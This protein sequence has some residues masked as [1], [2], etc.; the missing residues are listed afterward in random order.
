M[1]E[2][3]ASVKSRT[4]A[5]SFAES[6][7][8][9]LFNPPEPFT[10]I[11]EINKIVDW[12]NVLKTNF[13]NK[14]LFTFD[15]DLIIDGEKFLTSARFQKEFVLLDIETPIAEKVLI[16]LDQVIYNSY[17][18]ISLKIYD[19]LEEEVYIG[20][21][22]FKLYRE[23]LHLKTGSFLVLFW[24]FTKPLTNCYKIASAEIDDPFLD[25]IK[26]AHFSKQ[27]VTEIGNSF[28]LQKSRESADNY[29]FLLNQTLPLS[30]LEIH[31]SMKNSGEA[32][33]VYLDMPTPIRECKHTPLAF[34]KSQQTK[35]LNFLVANNPYHHMFFS[36]SVY[37]D[38]FRV[39]DFPY[40]F[41]RRENPVITMYKDNFKEGTNQDEQVNEDRH[42]LDQI[43][44]LPNFF[45]IELEDKILINKSHGYLRDIP[46]ALPKV[47]LSLEWSRITNTG[48]LR[49]LLARWKSI[50]YDDALFLLSHF[51][52]ANDIY[53]AKICDGHP[54]KEEIIRVIRDYAVDSL[55]E[56]IK[57]LEFLL[58]QLTASLKY[59]NYLHVKKSPLVSFM[60]ENLLPNQKLGAHFYWMLSV[61]AE[62]PKVQIKEWYS[63][64]Q[65]KFRDKLEKEKSDEAVY[66]NNFL[67]FRECLRLGFEKCVRGQAN[68]AERKQKTRE[69]F[70]KNKV[71][72]RILNEK[73]FFLFRSDNR[74]VRLNPDRITVFSSNTAPIKLSFDC[75][76]GKVFEMMYKYSDD[77][78][79]D[80]LIMQMI[81]FMDH[82]LQSINVDL[83][84]TIYPI[85]AFS[86]EDGIMEFVQNSNTMQKAIYHSQLSTYLIDLSKKRSEAL[87]ETAPRMAGVTG[88]LSEIREDVLENYK[89][90]CA[91]YCVITYLL[92]IGDRH[93]ENIMI[94]NDGK[95]FHID[96]GYAMGEDPKGWPPPFKLTRQMISIFTN[97]LENDFISRCV[98]YYLKV[99]RQAKLIL[100]LMNSMLDSNLIISPKKKLKMSED[101]LIQMA[102]KF[103][104]EEEEIEVEKF[105]KGIFE[106][107]I[108]AMWTKVLD[109]IH[110]RMSK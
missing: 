84:L 53:P 7:E 69:F 24:P 73:K 51:F 40:D 39:R 13:P 82:V 52:S 37:S 92:G 58:L 99:R 56:H 101:K 63:K 109:E 43:L 55:R 11:I 27:N 18:N 46:D 8:Y 10:I 48:E 22:S 110:A 105:F 87:R 89:E 61:E 78:R 31:V 65:K 98:T 67:A 80:Q 49:D 62:S 29:N 70:V 41:K 94:S 26:R 15:F 54:L 72:A 103:R 68:H 77:L 25:I 17:L 91:S 90:S 38:M 42:R 81:I 16:S 104:M 83:R 28:L 9:Q 36:P 33:V 21:T 96:F 35:E 20:T 34:P 5:H 45:P 14:Y 97:A 107:S 57:Q 1:T 3:A 106:E 59:E 79:L 71:L 23:D 74:I 66:L 60:F 2:R 32:Q 88:L 12:K 76:N 19:G 64:I 6:L 44:A 30:F 75:E 102:E 95:F 100:N 86:P 85:L 50:N 108:N 47:L 93:L 4:T